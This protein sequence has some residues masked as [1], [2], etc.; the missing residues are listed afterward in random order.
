MDGRSRRAL[1]DERVRP[2]AVPEGVPHLVV[3]RAEARREG[4]HSRRTPGASHAPG[5][6]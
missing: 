2:R 4:V 3:S 5:A 1:S 6:D